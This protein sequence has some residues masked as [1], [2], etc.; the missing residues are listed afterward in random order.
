MH[1]QRLSPMVIQAAMSPD[2]ACAG[3]TLGVPAFTVLGG[4]DALV[5]GGAS[6]RKGTAST[7]ET[8]YPS[9]FAAASRT[10]LGARIL[11]R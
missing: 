10:V 1:W 11:L 5:I 2:E 4:P 3:R 7:V 9:K 6:G 8:F